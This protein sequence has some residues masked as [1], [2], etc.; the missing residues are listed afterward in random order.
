MKKQATI[1]ARDLKIAKVKEISDKIGKAKTLV[2]ADYLGLTVNQINSLRQK[3]KVAGGE[4]IVAKNTLLARALSIHH[5]PLT[6][7][8]L[9]GPTAALFAYE[10][11]IAPI[12][13]VADIAK[14]L[15]FP[16]FKFGFFDKDFLDQ[17]A[18]EDLAKIPTKNALQTNLVSSLSSPIYGIVNV[19]QANIRNL[20]SVL[21]QAS[22]VK[23]ASQIP[24]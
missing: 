9:A 11:E 14:T 5:S 7:N 6:I 20:V 1:K 15:G 19:L 2:F 24:L 16:K 22:K 21:D 8:Q 18:V 12:K 10:D 13:I 23:V 4:L 17:T 3:V